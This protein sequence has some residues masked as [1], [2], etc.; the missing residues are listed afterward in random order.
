MVY[1]RKDVFLGLFFEDFIVFF[2]LVILVVIAVQCNFH[3]VVHPFV[4]MKQN[5][6]G[7]IWVHDGHNICGVQNNWVLGKIKTSVIFMSER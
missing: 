6:D 5:P 4:T 2:Q 7:Y 3:G 1:G